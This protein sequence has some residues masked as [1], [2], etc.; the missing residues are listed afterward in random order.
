MVS[1]MKDNRGYQM[2]INHGYPITESILID[3]P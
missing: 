3:N 1:V 2:V